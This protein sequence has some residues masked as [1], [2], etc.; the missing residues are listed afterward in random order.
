MK[1]KLLL[2]ILLFASI[3][4]VGQKKITVSDILN[5][6][7][8]D[9]IQAATI[10]ELIELETDDNTWMSYNDKLITLIEKKLKTNLDAKI[11]KS[12]LTSLASCYGNRGYYYGLV[13]PNF[14][15]AMVNYNKALLLSTKAEDIESNIR[16]LL[17]IGSCENQQGKYENSLQTFNKAYDNALEINNLILQAKALSEIADIYFKR[18]AV[19]KSLEI[20]T[21]SLKILDRTTD[22][23]AKADTRRLMSVIYIKQNEFNIAENL[24]KKNYNYYEKIPTD[25]LKLIETCFNLSKVYYGKKDKKKFQYYSDKG[26]KDALAVNYLEGLTVFYRSKRNFFINEKEIDSAQKYSDL[27][28]KLISTIKTEPNFSLALLDV[29]DIYK[30][31]KQY[32]QAEQLGLNAFE[33]MQKMGF[34]TNLQRAAQNLKEIYTLVNN[35]KK[36]LFYAEIELKIIDSLSKINVENSAIKS[37]F[38]YETE[39]KEA[40]IKSLSQQKRISE[41]ENKRQKT[42]LLLLI[43]GI[44]SALIT[45]YLLFKRYK[46]KKQNELLKSEIEKTQA[47]S[48]ATESE[49]KALKSQ[50]NPHFIFNALNSIQEQFMFGD[51]LVANEQ[52]GNFTSLTRQILT[53]SGKKKIPVS[54][55]I[56]ILTKYLEL[57]K[58]RFETDFEYSINCSENIDDEYVELPPMLIQP[59]VEN[60]IKHGLLHKEGDKKIAVHFALNEDETYLIC[61]VED[62][63]IGRKKAQEIKQKN[64]HNSFSTSSVAQRLQI[65]NN[66][67]NE[68]LIYE[69]LE[70]ENGNSLGTKVVLKIAM[71]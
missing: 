10:L 70:D 25:K 51:K 7:T 48:K 46:T 65:I 64:I 63:G 28:L 12:L 31:K 36:A 21:K 55:E 57:E 32:Q 52:M 6:K 9:T 8:V 47:Q 66:D 30:V 15:I 26:I 22:E 13:S 4:A 19:T 42:T 24:L 53:V 39:K 56:D 54:L 68:N 41:L 20:F 44:I 29:S 35:S 45:S 37:L 23:P 40:E 71:Q 67:E 27:N 38:A 50:M 60:S 1:K 62:N 3:F 11:K 33:N 5:L 59:F 49:L 17:S 2:L 43:F 18:G 16:I 34:N 69:D 14:D 61:T 58:M